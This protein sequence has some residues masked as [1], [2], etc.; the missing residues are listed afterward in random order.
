MCRS[1]VA[2]TDQYSQSNDSL[3]IQSYW[4]YS[5]AM[6]VEAWL[7]C[8]SEHR[9]IHAVSQTLILVWVLQLLFWKG[10]V[11][12][13]ICS[14]DTFLALQLISL[15][16]S[17]LCPSHR[18]NNRS[19][20]SITLKCKTKMIHWLLLIVCDNWWGQWFQSG[21]PVRSNTKFLMLY[22]GCLLQ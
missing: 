11:L 7:K 15:S 4:T 2:I 14:S 22:R 18:W 8:T 5:F 13:G 16:I 21:L 12:K 20:N 10:S 6:T 19:S 9:R 17:Q 1:H 3:C